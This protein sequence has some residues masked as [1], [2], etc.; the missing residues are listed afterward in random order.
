MV[1]Q[2]YCSIHI[3]LE[4]RRI[5]ERIQDRESIGAHAE[6]GLHASIFPGEIPVNH[7]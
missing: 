6:V 2:W 1:I 4:G 7:L 5:V 3:Y